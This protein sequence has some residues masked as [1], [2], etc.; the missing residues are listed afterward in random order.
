MAFDARILE[1]EALRSVPPL[2]LRAYALGEGWKKLESY[3]RHSDV[4]VLD[5]ATEA[6]IPG[7]T[8]LA[9]YASVVSQLI[10]L[11][12]RTEGRSELQV[13]RDLTIA[14]Q[15]VI[16]VRAPEAEDDGSV[17]LTAG[18]NLVVNARDMLLAAACS[19]NEPRATY[20][21]GKVKQANEY[22]DRVKLGQT[23]RG[24]FVL[25]IL[26]PVPPALDEPEEPTFWPS[27][28]D[29]PFARQVTRRFAEALEASREAIEQT[30]RGA[31]FDA[32]YK[33]V[34]LGIS[35]NLCEA[36]AKLIELGDGLDVSVTWARTRRTPEPSTR[37]RF[38]P[39]DASVLQ[40]AARL[41]REKEP[42]LDEVL[43]GH[44]AKLYR[45]PQAF[46]GR[47]TMQARVNGKQ[48]SVQID[49]SQKDYEEAVR[50][51]ENRLGVSITGDLEREGQR[52]KLKNPRQISVLDIDEAAE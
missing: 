50:A 23:E 40:E 35:A 15:D 3:G 8:A 17:R 52:W 32:F 21:A 49:L 9:D 18:V 16:R 28:Q 44:I 33:S 48:T 43:E 46:D 10:T 4:Y 22:M 26:S 39:A 41:F 12:A 24:S 2:A 7:T 38:L 45:E 36:A 5:G 6:I 13:F 1:T 47:I 31:G 42:R 19:A 27:A 51:H 34:R 30:N 20:R 29:E 37:V 11:F 14:D 25:T